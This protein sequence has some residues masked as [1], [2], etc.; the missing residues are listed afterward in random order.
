MTTNIQD[1]GDLPGRDERRSAAA[2]LAERNHGVQPAALA[3][4]DQ[5]RPVDP[6]E[7]A[8]AWSAIVAGD[9]I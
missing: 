5:A 2:L 1:C 3:F 4:E 7:R 8:Q 9:L 6:V